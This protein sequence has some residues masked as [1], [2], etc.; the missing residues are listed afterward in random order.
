MKKWFPLLVLALV[1]CGQAPSGTVVV[2]TP[3]PAARQTASPFPTAAAIT[4]P[5]EQES[6]FLPIT[7]DDWVIG[8]ETAAVTLIEYGDFQ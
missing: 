4:E 8:P 3:V 6:L 7:E 1:A 5:A 2:D